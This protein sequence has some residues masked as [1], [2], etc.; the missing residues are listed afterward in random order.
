METSIK[1]KRNKQERKIEKM[2]R[3]SKRKKKK[4]RYKEYN[5][6]PKTLFCNK[7]SKLKID[8]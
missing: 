7:T 1:K 2:E 8:N 3:R 6:A 5:I 4:W